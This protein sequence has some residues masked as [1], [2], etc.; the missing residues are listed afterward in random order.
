MML[1]ALV[2]VSSSVHK[3]S[4]FCV[5]VLKKEG[6]MRMPYL[7]FFEGDPYIILS[8][9]FSLFSMNVSIKFSGYTIVGSTRIILVLDSGSVEIER[10][11]LT[12]SF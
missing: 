9:F 3:F 6:L 11:I 7:G 2:H 4:S 1:E 12:E 8:L 10:I 5:I